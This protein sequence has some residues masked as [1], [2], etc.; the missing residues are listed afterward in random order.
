MLYSALNNGEFIKAAWIKDGAVVVD[1]CY[2]RRHR[3]EWV[4]MRLNQGKVRVEIIAVDHI[5]KMPIDN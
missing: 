5:G 4:C 2:T 1:A 3:A